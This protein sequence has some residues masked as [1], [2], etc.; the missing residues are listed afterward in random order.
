M[1]A[2]IQAFDIFQTPLSSQYPLPLSYTLQSSN[3]LM[4]Y[5]YLTDRNVIRY[6]YVLFSIY[7]GTKTLGDCVVGSEQVTRGS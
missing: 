6:T 2:K 3:N 7:L 1:G 4:K 5:R